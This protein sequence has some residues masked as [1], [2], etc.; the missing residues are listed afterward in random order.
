MTTDEFVCAAGSSCRDRAQISVQR[1]LCKRCTRTVTQALRAIGEDYS[2]LGAAINDRQSRGELVSGTPDPAIPL[3]TTVLA[4]RATLSEWS[5]CALW[6]V[7][8]SLGIDVRA[9][10]KAKGWPVKDGPLIQQ[11]ERILPQNVALLLR[12]P[13]QPVSV[14]YSVEGDGEWDSDD[15]D[16]IDVALRLANIHRQCKGL[17]GE[18]NPRR[19]LAMPCPVFDC[20]R[21]TLGINN[22]ESD[23][24]CS[25]C[26]GRWSELEYDWLARMLVD[27]H[28]RMETELLKW[29][30]AEAKYKLDVH[31]WL[32]AEKTWQCYEAARIGR[33]RHEDV[34]DYD[35][36]AV[37]MLLR[38]VFADK[39]I[40]E[41]ALARA[42]VSPA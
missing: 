18:A 21:R 29:L 6:M 27:D 30:L 2:R 9:R 25:S 36:W 38:E 41:S 26:G 4:L 3:N 13:K 22:G 37:V 33:L 23:V 31:A 20:G 32:L 11:A 15:L 5:E 28:T 16:G 1:G 24:T 17:L 42:Q 34:M 14:W 35:A 40:E 10:H 12:A 39:H 7:A 19:R 8:E